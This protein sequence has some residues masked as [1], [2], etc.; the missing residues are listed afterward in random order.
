MDL[1]AVSTIRTC[2]DM[3]HERLKYG[4]HGKAPGRG[5]RPRLYATYSS[6]G[7]QLTTFTPGATSAASCSGVPVSGGN[8][9]Q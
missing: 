6:P 1:C 5:R 8:V 4:E 9:P 7:F 2:C 3:N